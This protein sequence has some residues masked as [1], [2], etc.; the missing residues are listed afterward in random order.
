VQAVTNLLDNASK[1]T[2]DEGRISVA[3]TTDGATLSV[4]VTDDG[5]GITPAM[6]PRVFEPF[7]QD[8]PVLGLNGAGLGIGLTVA[9]KL[10]RAHGGDVV[11]YSDG[12][13]RGSRF[14]LTLPL[15]PPDGAATAGPGGPAGS[16]GAN[17]AGP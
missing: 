10:A 11:G 6:L 14:V 3:V 9:R 13:R 7:V 5:I 1:F 12:L 16:R 8:T 17:G 15:P 4:T 2:P